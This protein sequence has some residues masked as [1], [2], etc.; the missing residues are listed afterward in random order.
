MICIHLLYLKE[1][2]EGLR[3]SVR[4][5]GGDGGDGGGFI[6]LPLCDNGLL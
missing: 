4:E 5:A 6:E 2:E 3:K 1:A